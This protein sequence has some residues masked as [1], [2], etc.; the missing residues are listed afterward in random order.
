KM[1]KTL[2]YKSFN[3]LNQQIRI[4]RWEAFYKIPKNKLDIVFLG[5][6]HSY[7]TY[8]PEMI[9]SSLKINSFNMASNSQ[10]IDQLYFNLKEILKYQKPNIVFVELFSLAGNSRD[11]EGNWFV[12]DNLDGQKLNLNKLKTVLAYRKKRDR[13]N[14]LFPLIRSHNNWKKIKDIGETIRNFKNDK[15]I[16]QFRGF[17]RVQSEMGMGVKNQ[18]LAELKEDYKAFYI[19][20]FNKNYL[21]KIRKLSEKY[22]FKIIYVY[23]PMYRD[24]INPNYQN[25]HKHF[26]NLANLYADDLLDFNIIGKNIGMNERWFENGYIWY[27]HTSFYG[28]RKITEYVIDYLS[29]NYTLKSRESEKYWQERNR[30]KNIGYEQKVASNLELMNEIKIKEIVYVPENENKGILEIRFNQNEVIKEI[31]DYRL[32]IHAFPINKEEKK[33]LKNGYQNWDMEIKLKKDKDYFYINRE[34][35]P[36]LQEYNLNI[37]LY[38][39]KKDKNNK[40]IGYPNFG[41][42]LNIEFKN[43]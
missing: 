24:L 17:E 2:I 27:Q 43:K 29:K 14:S 22:N 39:I 12:Y 18:Y 26:L 28:A 7:T 4:K 6:S 36:Q 10:Q 32:K 19:S 40:V 11:N 23:S 34:I 37:A 35:D 20:E 31:E 9:D 38:K 5:S 1:K 3:K 41:N 42:Q 25:K 8:Y 16:E 15:D 30:R 33:L 21:K 13:L